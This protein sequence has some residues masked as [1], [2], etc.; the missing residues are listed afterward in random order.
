MNIGIQMFPRKRL[1]NVSFFSLSRYTNYP[2]LFFVGDVWAQRRYR[3]NSRFDFYCIPF[4]FVIDHFPDI[5]IFFFVTFHV[6]FLTRVVLLPSGNLLHS[7]S[8]IHARTF[9]SRP[10]K[11]C[12]VNQSSSII[13]CN[14]SRDIIHN[15]DYQFL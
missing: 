13:D 9:L 4:P 11:K 1:A 3:A 2:T 12:T 6:R 14:L 8:R 5:Y 7:H 10:R 15:I